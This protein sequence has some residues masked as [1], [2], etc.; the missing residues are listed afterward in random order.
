MIAFRIVGPN[1][2][3]A[4]L[5]WLGEHVDKARLRDIGEQ[6]RSLPR[7]SALVISPGWLEYEGIAAMRKRRT[8][9][10][11]A[12]PKSGEQ[13]RA[14]GQ[15][16]KPDLAKYRARLAEVVER[17][18]AD[19]PK[20]LRAR[21][22]ELEKLVKAKVPVSPA[23]KPSKVLERPVV[24]KAAITA[25]ERAIANGD[26]AVARAAALADR[27][28]AMMKQA[29]EL[30]AASSMRIEVELGKVRESLGAAV[31]QTVFVLPS[32]SAMPRQTAAPRSPAPR[33]P[34]ART[35]DPAPGD[36]SLEPRALKVLASISWWESVGVNAPDNTGVAFV[37]GY[38]PTSSGYEK[39]RGAL[40]VAGLINYPTPGT[41]ELTDAGRAAAP[42]TDVPFDNAGLH[43]AV[44]AKLDP[45]H[46]KMLRPLL[47]AY[48]ESLSMQDLGDASN[49]S[50]TSSG[51]E[52]V[53]GSLRTLGLVTY[54]QS[55]RVRAAD[56]L[57]PDGRQ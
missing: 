19:D 35:S 10:S 15:G 27:A 11:S 28:G 48:P 20:A 36:T 43:A 39:V 49:Y 6:L 24:A 55:G 50:P 46:G 25:L 56:L 44:L 57:F 22:A 4:V 26:K 51:F 34:T 3:R 54:P 5:D 17:V 38:S 13:V 45:R 41:I 16:A 7:G 29:A 33:P 9:D 14:S 40:R 8:F 42:P 52:K 53:R 37:A 32:A 47:D 18:K 23:V 21:V 1:S 2:M 12:T 30:M 31:T